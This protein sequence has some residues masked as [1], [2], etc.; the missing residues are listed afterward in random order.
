[1]AESV[2]GPWAKAK[3]DRLAKYLNAYTVIMKDRK[4]CKG[5][6]YIDAFAGPGEH[7]IRQKKDDKRHA[8][9]QALLDV[10]SFGSEQEEQRL[11]LAGSPRVALEVQF[12]FTNYVFIEHSPERVAS[13]KRLQA[14]Y[15]AA[16]RIHIRKEDCTK[17]LLDTI[18]ANPK[19]DWKTNRALVFLD[20]FGM[21]VG[22]QTIEAL[23][24]TKAIEIFLNFPVGMAI[25][26]LLLRQPDKF[27]EAQRRRLD[28]YFGSPNWMDALY[29]RRRTLFGDEAQDK[30]D[31]SGIAL[32][33]WYRGRLRKIFAHVSKAALIRN[34]RGGHLYYLLLASQNRTGVKIADDILSAGEVV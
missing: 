6:H 15:A 18:A 28:D 10:S 12:P 7:E 24:G 29:R 14:E 1:M 34:T 17:Y 26:R 9:Q 31:E 11:F 8:A 5:Y 16:R 27:T 23:A 33:N 25:Q 3:L 30:I 19:L 22:W 20:P 13:L 21:Q 4:W 2:I 32:L